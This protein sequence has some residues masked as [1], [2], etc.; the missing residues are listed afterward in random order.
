MDTVVTQDRGDADAREA[1]ALDAYSR[2]TGSC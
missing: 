1:D 2:S